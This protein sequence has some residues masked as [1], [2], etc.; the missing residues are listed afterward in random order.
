LRRVGL[1]H[2]QFADAA[3]ATIR[4]KLLKLGAAACAA[5]TSRLHQALT[6]TRT[7][8]DHI[9]SKQGKQEG[10]GRDCYLGLVVG[11]D[12]Q[13]L[14][15]VQPSQPLLQPAQDSFAHHDS[16][17]QCL[18]SINLQLDKSQPLPACAKFRVV[19]RNDHLPL[20]QINRRT[21]F[22]ALVICH[23]TALTKAESR[24]PFHAFANNPD[25]IA[26]A[27]VVDSLVYPGGNITGLSEATPH[28]TPDS[29]LPSWPQPPF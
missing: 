7:I 3:V 23:G 20:I 6:E 16:N 21:P 27:G 24:S 28:L 5:F 18:P 17:L 10:K 22:D 29:A 26:A 2:T 12:S 14:S 11:L 8:A 1:R 25:M 4:L 9:W 13:A 19:R 15:C